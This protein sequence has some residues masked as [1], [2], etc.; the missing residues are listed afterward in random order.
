MA[1]LIQPCRVELSDANAFIAAHHRHHKPVVGHRFSIGASVGGRL[2]GVA[3]VGRP[4][5]RMTD[6]KNIAEVT[7]LCTDG[8]LNACSF[9]YA[10]CAK[11][12]K[13]MGFLEIQTFI[14]ES[15]SGIT[16]KA[17]GWTRGNVSG[18]GTWNR[19]SRGDRREDQ[20]LDKKVR[21]YK[22]LAK[23]EE[24]WLS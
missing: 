15:E 1:E 4:V 17:A 10:T 16:L 5:A 21:W 22:K 2:V 14:L 3:I 13:L 12:A 24:E 8:S 19:P 11:I 6:Q 23:G 18:G 9:L 7:R 20:P